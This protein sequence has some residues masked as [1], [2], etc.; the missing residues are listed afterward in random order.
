MRVL[1]LKAGVGSVEI[2]LSSYIFNI[3]RYIRLP[4]LSTHV[5]ETSTLKWWKSNPHDSHLKRISQGKNPNQ[6]NLWKSF[7]PHLLFHNTIFIIH[8]EKPAFFKT[9]KKCPD[10]LFGSYFSPGLVITFA[11]GTSDTM[12]LKRVSENGLEKSQNLGLA[13]EAGKHRHE[14]RDVS[15]LG[16]F[17]F[18]K[19]TFRITHFWGDFWGSSLNDSALFGLVSYIMTPVFKRDFCPK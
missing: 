5:S 13:R 16:K 1:D 9:G 2:P 6:G 17:L 18:S 11:D 12:V 8:K 19:G 15:K 3:G 4:V 10:N 7:T 14:C